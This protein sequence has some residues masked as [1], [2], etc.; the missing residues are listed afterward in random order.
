ML[1]LLLR[2]VECAAVYW[3]GLVGWLGFLLGFLLGHTNEGH[4]ETHPPPPAPISSGGPCKPMQAHENIHTNTRT[5]AH[6]RSL[7]TLGWDLV[8]PMGLNLPCF[9]GGSARGGGS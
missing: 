9:V 5:S 2:V 3:V 6:S 4:E 1:V 7:I 8:A